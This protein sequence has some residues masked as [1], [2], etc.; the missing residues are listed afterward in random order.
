I[1]TTKEAIVNYSAQRDRVGE[2][3]ARA[4]LAGVHYFANDL[5]PAEEEE[6]RALPFLEHAP[7]YRA[8]LLAFMTFT[9]LMRAAPP[10]EIYLAGAEAMRLLEQVGGVTEGEALIRLAYAEGLYAKG[11]VE[12]ARKAV[13]AA[14]D[15][16]LARAAQIKNPDYKRSF[17]GNVRE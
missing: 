15:R 1:Q 2:G 10:D 12:G 8:A 7:P 16:L 3:R 6:L 11:D 5:V 4:Y 14:R 17:L 13:T 9:L